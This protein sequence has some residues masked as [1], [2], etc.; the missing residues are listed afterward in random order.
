MKDENSSKNKVDVSELA[1]EGGGRYTQPPCGK[2]HLYDLA[3]L[4]SPLYPSYYPNSID[5]NWTISGTN[6]SRILLTFTSFSL[7]RHLSCNYDY[8]DVYDG[9]SPNA[10]KI[11][12]YCGNELPRS[13][14]SSGSHLFI[15]FH[16]DS[17]E[18]R[19]GFVL[20]LISNKFH[21]CGKSH[22]YAPATL[23]SPLYPSYYP[24]SIDCNWTI[25]GTNGSKILLTFTSFSLEIHLRCDYDYL[26]VYDGDSS[27]ASKIGRYCGNQLPRSLTSS[28]SHLFIA[29]HSDSSEQRPGFV[30]NFSNKSR[31]FTYSFKIT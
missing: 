15:A 29:F 30:L 3:T 18:R 1:D 31:K 26:D 5:C 12:R 2:R 23:K 20:N 9:D 7:E 13:L 10:S 14:I 24:N 4:K 11:D 17:S 22:L 16:S 21:P 6:G 28:G 19:P 25:S 27:N 8:L